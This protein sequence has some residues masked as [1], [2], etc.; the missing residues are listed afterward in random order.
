MEH[1]KGRVG[2]GMVRMRAEYS[3]AWASVGLMAGMHDDYGSVALDL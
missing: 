1:P 3:I 2:A